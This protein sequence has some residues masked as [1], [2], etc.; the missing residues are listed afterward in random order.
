M[1]KIPFL[2]LAFVFFLSNCKEDK[3]SNSTVS[4]SVVYDNHTAFT[5]TKLWE[6]LVD[7]HPD[8][9][10]INKYT[11]HNYMSF[12]GYQTTPSS[13]KFTT[14][15][16]D[17]KE[18]DSGNLAKTLHTSL[19]K[20]GL[21]AAGTK[22]L[23]GSLAVKRNDVEIYRVKLKIHFYKI[24]H[25]NHCSWINLQTDIEEFQDN[26]DNGQNHI[27]YAFNVVKTDTSISSVFNFSHELAIKKEQAGKEVTMKIPLSINLD[28]LHITQNG[29]VLFE[30][31]TLWGLKANTSILND[32]QIKCEYSGFKQD[33]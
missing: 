8:F 3:P 31:Q 17:E 27:K 33:K 18:K 9:D 14:Y 21:S 13:S 5:Y 20:S 32:W 1:I 28:N 12:S 6:K 15:I 2:P 23:T 25:K 7:G 16:M 24:C 26:S 19:D 30:D 22:S 11:D 4:Y 29:E 10:T